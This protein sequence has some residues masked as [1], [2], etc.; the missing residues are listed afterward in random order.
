MTLE[1]W[2]STGTLLSLNAVV[3][4]QPKVK[5]A[6]TLREKANNELALER[7]VFIFEQQLGLQETIRIREIL[8]EAYHTACARLLATV[9]KKETSSDM[10]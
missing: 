6:M 7:T 8:R 5:A 1:T 4:K 9:Y 2:M 10:E 3:T